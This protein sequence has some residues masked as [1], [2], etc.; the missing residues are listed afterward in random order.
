MR[1]AEA[2]LQ[3]KEII[4]ILSGL[5]VVEKLKVPERELSSHLC[6]VEL[7]EGC[8]RL[9]DQLPGEVI[10]HQ[11]VRAHVILQVVPENTDKRHTS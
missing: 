11:G 1:R 7:Q 5:N 9:A 6:R 2:G 10:W 8:V 3:F 4:H